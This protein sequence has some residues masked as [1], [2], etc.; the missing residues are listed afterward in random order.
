MTK[1]LWIRFSTLI[2]STIVS[3][4]VLRAIQPA[5]ITLAALAIMVGSTVWLIYSLRKHE[6]DFADHAKSWWKM[7]WDAFWGL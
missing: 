1:S 7:M 5:L 2:F 6:R 4:W 3:W